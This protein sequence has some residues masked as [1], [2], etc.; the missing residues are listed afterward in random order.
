MRV[1][2]TGISGLSKEDFLEKICTLC[3]SKNLEKSAAD[4]DVCLDT[5]TFN[6]AHID[7]TFDLEHEMCR[8]E[9]FKTPNYL[10]IA[11]AKVATI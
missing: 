4:P 11:D 9:K 7:L 6:D 8:R 5:T 2:L 3:N 1:V 10:D